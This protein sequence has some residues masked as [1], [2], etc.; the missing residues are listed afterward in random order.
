MNDKQRK[1]DNEGDIN[2]IINYVVIVALLTFIA[3]FIAYLSC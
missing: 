1:Q 2:F 3:F